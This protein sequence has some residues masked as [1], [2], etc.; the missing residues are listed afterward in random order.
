[1]IYTH[2][3]DKDY[4]ISLWSGG[5]TIQIAI[6]PDGAVYADRDFLWRIS[7]ATAEIDESDYTELPDY[8]RLIAVFDQ[9]IRLQHDGGDIIT[10]QPYDVHRFDGASRTHS[11]GRCADFNLMM[12][13]GRVDGAMTALNPDGD[14]AI[15]IRDVDTVLIYCAEGCG[16]INDIEFKAGEAVMT[17]EIDRENL[18]LHGTGRFMLAGISVHR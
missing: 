17:D 5:R 12:R 1:M 2:L 9:P 11:W 18:L 14:E 4:N 10:L 6:A 7:S 15:D 3:T 8:D 13:K 16:I